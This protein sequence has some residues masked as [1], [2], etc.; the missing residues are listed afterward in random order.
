LWQGL[1]LGERVQWT[2][3]LGA[4]IIVVGTVVLMYAKSRANPAVSMK[5]GKTPLLM[6]MEVKA[7]GPGQCDYGTDSKYSIHTTT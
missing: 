2:S 5:D 7:N 6:L 4:S 3:I 1:V